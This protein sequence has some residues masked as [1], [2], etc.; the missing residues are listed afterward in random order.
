MFVHSIILLYGLNIS[1]VPLGLDGRSAAG[2]R[3]NGLNAELRSPLVGRV[4]GAF[5]RD[6]PVVSG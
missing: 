2:A 5:R 4:S 1:G 6:C 3:L